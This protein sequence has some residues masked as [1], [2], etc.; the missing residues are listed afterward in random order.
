MVVV[1]VL[2]YWKTL[3]THQFTII[4]GSEGVNMSWAW[5]H[6]LVDS[7]RHGRIPLWDP[8]EFAGSPFAGSMQPAVY[9][10]IQALFALLPLTRDGFIST[11][12]F[13]QYLALAHLLGAW[14]AFALL[15]ELRRSHFASFVGGCVFALSGLLVRMIWPLYIESCIWIPAIFLFLL[16]ALRTE[17]RDRAFLEAAFCGFCLAMSIFTGGMAFVI[18]QAIALLGA[19][20]WYAVDTRAAETSQVRA[21]WLR[22][23]SILGIAF[24][25]A[26]GLS[27]VQLIPASEYGKQTLR[28]IDGGQFPSAEKIPFHRLVPGVWPESIVSALFPAGFNGKIGGEEYFPFYVGVFPL[29]LAIIAIWK[30]WANLWVRYL[31]ILALFAFLYAMGE[32][33]PLYGV[34]YAITPLLWMTRGGNRF[35]YLISFALAILSAFGLDTLLDHATPPGAWD[36]TKPFLKW[37]AISA[38]AALVLPGL[39]DKLNLS[40]WN[41]FSLLLILGSCA[42]FA[43]LTTHRPTDAVRA[44]LAA[45]ILFDLS[46]FNWVEMDKA[47]LAKDGDQ[48]EQMISLRGAAEFVKHQPG[49]HR[50]RVAVEPQPNIGDVY[51]VESIWGGGAAVLTSYSS[52]GLHDDL[53]NVSY[54]IKPAAAADPNPVYHD[55]NWKV[56]QA[57]NAFSRAWIVHKSVLASTQEAAFHQLDQQ[58]LHTTAILE[59]SP[60]RPLETAKVD[61]ESVRFSSWAPESFTANATAASDGLLVLS[62]M[63]YPGW[64]ATV[65]GKSAQIYRVDGALRG[66]AV[67]PGSN[68][69]EIEYAP[70]SFRLGAVISLISLTL[71]LTG[72]VYVGRI[73]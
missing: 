7:F 64:R 73:P 62:E 59:T 51:G 47:V 72:W 44:L 1:I 21:H 67:S 9:Y 13:H 15:R 30:C 49:L 37:I 18:M 63:Y 56:Y 23:A 19:V 70:S 33:S 71:F 35:F 66:I 52:L 4:I 25:F 55:S 12:F 5:L 45:F 68:R 11:A 29:V 48:L 20:V 24:V 36:R 50:V 54:I 43:W 38:T 6:F 40:I 60:P 39:Y 46:A 58:D 41:A 3:L 27:A 28:F 34:L 69:I 8:Y 22:A 61:I 16:R 53:L 2:F 26:A 42:W 14:F 10:P 65:N 57:P 17:R 31:G 32:F